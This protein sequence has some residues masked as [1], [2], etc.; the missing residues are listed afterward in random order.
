MSRLGWFLFV[1]VLLAK[2]VRISS[3][4]DVESP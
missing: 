3:A 2:T 1:V 4:S